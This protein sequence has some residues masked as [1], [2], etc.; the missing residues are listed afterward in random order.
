MTPE[1]PAPAGNRRQEQKAQT[2]SL[3]LDAAR[4]LFEEHGF[5]GTT[6]RAVAA[7]AEVGLG[8][9]FSHFPDKASL[10]V[11]ALL[12][13]LAKE[14]R[15][16]LETFPKDAPIRDQIL[17]FAKAG[18]G[19]WC[20][21]PELSAT[22]LREWWFIKGP[23]AEKRREE[24]A[25]FIE[26]VVRILEGAQQRGELRS[27]VGLQNAAEALYSF[28]VGRLIRAAGEDRFDI[29]VLLVSMES[30]V[31]DLLRGIGTDQG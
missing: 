31:D 19:Y 11:A 28:Y 5:G 26:L 21:R 1:K 2:G 16:I 3:I 24:T 27:E 8:T 18:F 20:L 17:H 13:D 29:D 23:W 14:D 4:T 6:M 10:L 30:F 15:R 22:L 12:E 7:R 9:I 25:R